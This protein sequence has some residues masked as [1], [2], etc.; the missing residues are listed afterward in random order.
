MLKIFEVQVH[1][2]IVI[3]ISIIFNRSQEFLNGI[4]DQQGVSKD[5]HDFN[6]RP[7]Q[8]EVVFNNGDETVRDDGHMY[9]YSN[10]IL[11]F[12]PKGFDTQMLLNP[13]EKL[14]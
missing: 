9:L 3:I 12:S 10:S 5:A 8:F 6:D 11:R 14:M 13:L 2:G 4:L 7:V 1:L